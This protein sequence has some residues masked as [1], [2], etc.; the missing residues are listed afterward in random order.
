MARCVAEGPPNGQRFGRQF[1][2]EGWPFGRGLRPFG[3]GG[4]LLPEGGGS[5]FGGPDGEGV[6]RGFCLSKNG[7]AFCLDDGEELTEEQLAQLQ[8][9]MDFI[10]QFG[11]AGILDGFFADVPAAAGP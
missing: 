10:L 5:W 1:G 7:E 6:E 3:E 2:E 11:L 9:L 8:E 4:G